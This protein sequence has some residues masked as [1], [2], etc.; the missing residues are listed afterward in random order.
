MWNNPACSKC[1]A[2]REALGELGVPVTLRPYLEQP[3]TPQELAEVLDRLGKPPWDVC[4]LGEPVAESLGL[5]GWA[6]DEA[7]RQKWIEAMCRYPSLIQRPIVLL[8]N[9]SAI[10]ARTP[11]ALAALS[12]DAQMR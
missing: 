1:A 8:D 9:G 4:R 3:P 12:D 5:S 2:A 6:R 7:S 11:E 10:V